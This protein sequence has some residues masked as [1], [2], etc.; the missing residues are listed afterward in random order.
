MRVGIALTFGEIRGICVEI[1]YEAE[2]ETCRKSIDPEQRV[3]GEIF[4]V[5]YFLFLYLFL[6]ILDLPYPHLLKCRW[7]KFTH[8]LISSVL[9]KISVTDPPL[10]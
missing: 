2:T 5:F 4:Y 9:F 7:Q 6:H 1:Q 3:S 10:N 8:I